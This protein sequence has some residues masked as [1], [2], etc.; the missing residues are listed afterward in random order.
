V[1]SMVVSPTVWVFA[2]LSL[3]IFLFAWRSDNASSTVA[4]FHCKPNRR[5]FLL[6]LLAIQS[7]L[8][9]ALAVIDF[10]V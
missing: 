1:E 2:G 8:I 4:F 3:L 9:L 7:T 5:R 6:A 10:I